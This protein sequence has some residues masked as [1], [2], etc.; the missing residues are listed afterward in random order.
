[1]S[2]AAVIIVFIKVHMPGVQSYISEGFKITH[3]SDISLLKRLSCRPLANSLNLWIILD[4][5]LYLTMNKLGLQNH[6]SANDL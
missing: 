5:E 6:T 4:T 1:M 3:P 2:H